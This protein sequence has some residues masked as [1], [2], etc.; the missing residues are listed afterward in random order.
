MENL[1]SL[2]LDWTAD[3]YE[4]SVFFFIFS[5][6]GPIIKNYLNSFDNDFKI[7]FPGAGCP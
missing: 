2:K 7:A 3:R 6:S 1:T 4:K 5:L